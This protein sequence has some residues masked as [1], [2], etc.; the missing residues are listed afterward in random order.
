VVGGAS[1]LIVV[2]AVLP[3]EVL[4]LLLKVGGAPDELGPTELVAAAVVVL[5]KRSWPAGELAEWTA[6][7][8]SWW[9]SERGQ[10]VERGV[11][12][13]VG[14]WWWWASSSV[15]ASPL[16][17]LAGSLEEGA[18]VKPLAIAGPLAGETGADDAAAAAAWDGLDRAGANI[19][20][21][22]SVGGG[23]GDALLGAWVATAWPKMVLWWCS[24]V[25]DGF[26]F[27]ACVTR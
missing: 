27:V 23:G 11:T 8:P 22:T 6:P 17:T 25:L 26:L 12:G 13:P 19:V 21:L 18:C 4:L 2:A 24:L 10:P 15:A 1:G 7:A 14:C 5:E 20:E 3:I 16:D 9:R